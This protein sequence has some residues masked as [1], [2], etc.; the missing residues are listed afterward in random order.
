MANHASA[1]TTQLYDRR[2]DETNLDDVVSADMHGTAAL[3]DAKPEIVNGETRDVRGLDG[4]Q[5][6]IVSDAG[7]GSPGVT[8]EMSFAARY[9]ARRCSRVPRL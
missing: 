3:P 1:R 6:G 5:P 7:W 4:R 2:L 9:V 8:H